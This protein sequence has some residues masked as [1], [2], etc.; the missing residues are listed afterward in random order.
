MW[1]PVLFRALVAYRV[2]YVGFKHTIGAIN[3][4]NC[5]GLILDPFEHL[6]LADCVEKVG[7]GLRIR[8]VR[9]RD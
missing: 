3:L 4:Q 9:V 5:T 2:G 6:L 8:K 1:T 7:H